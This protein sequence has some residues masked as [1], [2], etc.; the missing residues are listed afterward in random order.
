VALVLATRFNE[1][2]RGCCSTRSKPL[3]E[4]GKLWEVI[5]KPEWHELQKDFNRITPIKERRMARDE[6]AADIWGRDAHPDRGV[7][8]AL[9]KERFG[10]A[11]VATA[12]AHAQVLRL[13]LLYAV[14]DKAEE[15]R[16]EHLDAALA[17]W[18]Y[19][20]DS[21]RFVFGD[22]LGDPVADSILKALRAAANG[23]SR[24][25]VRDFFHRKKQEGEINR[26]LL[27][28]HQKG[29]ARF[30]RRETGGR[31]TELWFATSGTPATKGSL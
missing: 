6:E 14:L 21:A 25:E 31:P 26:A 30:D 18:K 12:R 22:A 23:L 4:G 2:I 19:C 1:G 10:L 17:V 5:E 27:L 8:A 16:P 3:P 20:E 9:T 29:M 24:T 11:G 28:L 13:S 15:I 7:Y